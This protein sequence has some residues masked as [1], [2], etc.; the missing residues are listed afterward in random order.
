MNGPYLVK[1]ISDQKHILPTSSF[2]PFTT[3]FSVQPR[4]D[5]VENL[6]FGTLKP[7]FYKTRVKQ[8]KHFMV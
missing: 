8:N 3:V 5:I 1:G 4:L 6:A 2:V 7:N